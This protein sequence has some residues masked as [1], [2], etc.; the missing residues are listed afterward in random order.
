VISSDDPANRRRDPVSS[1]S[2]S[3]EAR[4]GPGTLELEA[5]SSDESPNRLQ[6]VP[7]KCHSDPYTPNCVPTDHN[8]P[9]T[10]RQLDSVRQNL[11]SPSGS[12][13][14]TADTVTGGFARRLESGWIGW[15]SASDAVGGVS[16][17]LG[18]EWVSIYR[19]IASPY[20]GKSTP[21]IRK[22]RLEKGNADLAPRCRFWH[23]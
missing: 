22:A 16:G 4:A 2:A 12:Q 15:R 11:S 13:V 9:F 21:Y 3:V 6:L 17:I 5:V 8:V 19:G 10:R 20:I 1:I 7:I 14:C 23:A 18:W